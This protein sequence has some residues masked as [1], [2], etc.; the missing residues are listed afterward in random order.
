MN[1]IT[2]EMLEQALEEKKLEVLEDYKVLDFIC[3]EMHIIAKK[4]KD[5][6]E[7]KDEINKKY[8]I[9]EHNYNKGILDRIKDRHDKHKKINPIK[10]IMPIF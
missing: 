10:P 2:W 6:E 9:P 4:Y 8:A 3:K 1:E 7:I 5:K